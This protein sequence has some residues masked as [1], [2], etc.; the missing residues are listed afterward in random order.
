MADERL[1]DAGQSG[2]D[3]GGMMRTLP[4]PIRPD[5]IYVEW[6]GNKRCF[7]CN[8][9]YEEHDRK[10]ARLIYGAVPG[11]VIDP[12]DPRPTRRER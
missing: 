2:Y 9:P 1:A 6:A 12:I 10:S 11:W 8:A 7:F 4:T 5:H 3:R